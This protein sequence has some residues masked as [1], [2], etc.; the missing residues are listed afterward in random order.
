MPMINIDLEDGKE[1]ICFSLSLSDIERFSAFMNECQGFKLAL[2]QITELPAVRQD[3]ACNIALS[4]F[5]R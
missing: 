5:R 2:Q 1:R 3:E 4:A